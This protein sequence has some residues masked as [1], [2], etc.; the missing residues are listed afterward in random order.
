MYVLK[1]ALLELF[2]VVHMHV[3]T[4]MYIAITV[5]SSQT[6]AMVSVKLYKDSQCGEPVQH[7]LVLSLVAPVF[8]MPHQVNF[9][10]KLYNTLCLCRST[11]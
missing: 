9:P 11:M 7:S 1:C 6:N 4:Y 8:S 10:T 3:Y 2:Y 5:H